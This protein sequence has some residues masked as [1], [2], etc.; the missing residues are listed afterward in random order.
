MEKKQPL[1]DVGK[2]TVFHDTNDEWTINISLGP[3]CVIL[4]N[5][6]HF[7]SSFPLGLEAKDYAARCRFSWRRKIVAGGD[8]TGRRSPVQTVLGCIRSWPGR[9]TGSPPDFPRCPAASC[10][11]AYTGDTHRLSYRGSAG[12]GARTKCRTEH[13]QPH[14]TCNQPQILQQDSG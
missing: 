5:Y 4:H 7:R 2:L 12:P 3:V 10:G 1:S 11:T 6:S 14:R 8:A 9:C 13:P